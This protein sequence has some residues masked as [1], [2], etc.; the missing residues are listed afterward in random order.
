MGQAWGCW[1][2]YPPL[3]FGPIPVTW[4]HNSK[5]ATS[6]CRRGKCLHKQ[7]ISSPHQGQQFRHYEHEVIKWLGGRQY[8]MMWLGIHSVKWY[9]QHFKKSALKQTLWFFYNN[10]E[11]IYYFYLAVISCNRILRII[12]GVLRSKVLGTKCLNQPW[13]YLSLCDIGK[14][15]LTFSQFPQINIFSNST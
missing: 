2:S 15:R 5:L 7:L 9:L 11:K 3:S 10:K 1:L 6:V 4:L 14:A 12:Y 8:S 13:L